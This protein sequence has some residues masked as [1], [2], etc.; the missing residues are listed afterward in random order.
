V[1][2]LDIGCGHGLIAKELSSHFQRVVAVD[3]SERMIEQAKSSVDKSSNITFQVGGAEELTG[4]Q[5]CSQDLVIAGQ[6]AHWFDFS[7]AWKEIHRV[8]HTGGTVCFWGYKDNYFVDY[9]AATKTLDKYCY[10]TDE[11]MMGRYWEQPGRQILRDLYKDIHPPEDLFADV[12]RI[13][14]EPGTNG[15][16]S[17]TLGDRMMFE[18]TTLGAMMA[19]VRTFSAYHN[20]AEAY[21]ERKPRKDG[22]KGDI[23][24]DMFDEMLEAEPSWKKEGDK[25]MEKEVETEWGSVILMA[26]KK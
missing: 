2:A 22:G 1:S 10:S 5:D 9:P 21:P 19:Y 12:E 25:W 3:P 23:V 24:D 11:G 18:T 13:L 26:R 8:L 16:S 15:P 17:G 20:W 4:L 7:K 14:Y 6:A